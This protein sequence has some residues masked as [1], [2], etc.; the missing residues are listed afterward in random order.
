[1]P[2][3]VCR[4]ENKPGFR[5]GKQGKCFTYTPNNDQS[6]EQARGQ[7]AAQGRA[8]E[9]QGGEKKKGFWNS[10]FEIKTNKHF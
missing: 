6:R 4:S 9:A 3:E 2:V 7:A 5:W 1:M 8:I 10:L